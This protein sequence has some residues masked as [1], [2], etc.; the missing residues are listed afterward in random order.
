LR[1]HR[2]RVSPNWRIPAAELPA[3]ALFCAYTAP[4]APDETNSR[5][6]LQHQRQCHRI[7]PA[8]SL[9]LSVIISTLKI[10]I[11][12]SRIVVKGT[13]RSFESVVA[14][15]GFAFEK[16]Q[17]YEADLT[18][19]TDQDFYFC[20]V[21]PPS[22]KPKQRQLPM[23]RREE[24]SITEPSHDTDGHIFT[25]QD[26]VH[27]ERKER[28]KRSN[29][30]DGED[31]TV[32]TSDKSEVIENSSDSSTGDKEQ[33]SD[34][35]KE[36]GDPPLAILISRGQCSFE[37]KARNVNLYNSLLLSD[38]IAR[39]R[40]KIDALGSRPISYVI[41][42]DNYHPY[43]SSLIVMGRENSTAADNSAASD[44]K[45][46]SSSYY[47]VSSVGMI[48]VKSSAGNVLRR[49]LLGRTSPQKAESVSIIILNENDNLFYGA[50]PNQLP[51]YYSSDS[52]NETTRSGNIWWVRYFLASVFVMIPIVKIFVT[53][54]K[55]RRE[56]RRRERRR[57][58][59]QQVW[60]R[61]EN[62]VLVLTD[63][64][65]ESDHGAANDDV[66]LT[67]EE[68]LR[69]PVV[70]HVGGEE[71]ADGCSICL[72]EYNE[73]Q[74]VR[75]LL[76][77]RH[78]FHTDCIVP[79]LTQRSN[80]CPLC[81]TVVSIP[82]AEI[83]DENKVDDIE[84]KIQMN[85]D[86]DKTEHPR[87]S[88]GDDNSREIPDNEISNDDAIDSNALLEH[89]M[90]HKTSYCIDSEGDKA[91]TAQS[92]ALHEEQTLDDMASIVM[93][94]SLS[95]SQAISPRSTGLQEEH[96]LGD[97]A[98]IDMSVSVSSA[99][100]TNSLSSHS[101]SV[102]PLLA[103]PQLFL[104]SSSSSL[105]S[106]SLSSSLPSSP[107]T[108]ASQSKDTF[109]PFDV[110]SPLYDENDD[111]SIIR[112]SLS[113]NNDITREHQQEESSLSSIKRSLSSQL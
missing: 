75:M 41:V 89:F 86:I 32:G 108:N 14:N 60:V 85:N 58:Y 31:D 2:C 57:R 104:S 67:T 51:A 70:K 23:L 39:K 47:D 5:V 45:K 37:Q 64:V 49:Q 101:I 3:A 52:G 80:Y 110:S 28:E 12:E 97:M 9:L 82:S 103:P 71:T 94:A 24:P 18:I 56:R 21:T 4:E 55:G 84:D 68:V 15:F 92:S 113:Q 63:R 11:N 93:L 59:V 74:M 7:R 10:P 1:H 19:L 42:H 20:R 111:V 33:S 88:D 106:S 30:F 83:D 109:S 43:E 95:S 34:N 46:G 100:S 40:D 81:K 61:D 62:G 17:L 73:G 53:Y 102:S 107:H 72:D 79:W 44:P 27:E 66:C 76:P 105:S 38:S 112:R 96:A 29:V 35:E 91:S 8:L 6:M 77:C 78:L 25:K 87:R 98:S 65:E 90:V 54:I 50:T 36:I 13:E 22:R 69:L 26:R 99:Q 16:N 48:F